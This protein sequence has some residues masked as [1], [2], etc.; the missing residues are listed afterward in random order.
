MVAN[1]QFHTLSAW[2]TD[3]KT[4]ADTWRGGHANGKTLCELIAQPFKSGDFLRMPRLCMTSRM[5]C[6]LNWKPRGPRAV[7]VFGLTLLER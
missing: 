7:C 5:P 1:K 3:R 2:L 6:W 4:T